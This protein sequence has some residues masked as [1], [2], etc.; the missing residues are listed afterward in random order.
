LVIIIVILLVLILSGC[1]SHKQES[2]ENILNQPG[3]KEAI[4]DY[5]QSNILS[6]NFGGKVFCDYELFGTEIKND[7]VY[8]Y[9]WTLCME[10]YLE[11]DGLKEG[12]GISLPIVL[13]VL[14]LGEGYKIIE[15]K[16]PA[17]GEG[18][19]PDYKEI[20][21]KKYHKKIFP[22]AEEYNR[23]ADCLSKATEEQAR[24]YYDLEQDV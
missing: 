2:P 12:S 24:I 3:L 20:F 15:H 10:Y 5:L 14:S 9:L 22:V 4:Y 11:D 7:R 19:Y 21:P 16:Q 18:T 23:R 6:P 8:I 1:Q 13:T 17:D